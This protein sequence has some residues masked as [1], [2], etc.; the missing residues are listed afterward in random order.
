MY[1][2]AEDP[3]SGSLIKLAGEVSLNPQTGQIVTTFK[4]TPDVPFENLELHFFGGE[5]APL[6]TPTRC[7]TYTTTAVVHAVGRQRSRDL[8]IVVQDRTRPGR[9]PVSRVRP[10]RSARL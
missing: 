9:W 3:F 10:C 8:G 2:V 1:I 5:R 4:N 7:G 6:A